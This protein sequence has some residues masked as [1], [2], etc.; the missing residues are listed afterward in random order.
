MHYKFLPSFVQRKGRITKSQEDNLNNLHSYQIT[1]HSQ[2]LSEKDNFKEIILEIGFG[3]GESLVN[4]AKENPHNLYIG[5]EVYMAGIG[6]VL[7]A[8]R[9]VG[10]NL[11]LDV[12][13]NTTFDGQGTLS[14]SSSGALKIDSPTSIGV[15]LTQMPLL[16]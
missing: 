11:D 4:L 7:G 14:V 16:I 12:G 1:S 5:S 2:I 13:G 15:V 10:S 3:N 6:Q 9:D 8:I